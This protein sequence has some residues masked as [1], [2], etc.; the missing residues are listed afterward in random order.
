MGVT[1]AARSLVAIDRKTDSCQVHWAELVYPVCG[2]EVNYEDV[3]S[4]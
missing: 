2:R 3:D 4:F 1:V